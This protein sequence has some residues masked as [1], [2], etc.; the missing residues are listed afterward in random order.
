MSQ[1]FPTGRSTSDGWFELES[2]PFSVEAA[3]QPEAG[4]GFF[5]TEGLVADALEVV[6]QGEFRPVARAC[7]GLGSSV[8]AVDELCLHRR[9]VDARGYVPPLPPDEAGRRALATY[10]GNRLQFLFGPLR[11]R[12]EYMADA[13]A[14]IEDMKSETNRYRYWFDFV[15]AVQRLQDSHSTASGL[16]QFVQSNAGPGRI[17]LNV[18][19]VNG[20]ADLSHGQVPRDAQMPDVLVSHTGEGATWGLQAGDRLVAIDGQHPVSWARGLAGRSW[21]A[22]QV[23]DPASP[24][25]HLEGLRG[26]IPSLARAITVIRCPGGVC[27]A[28]ETL[29]VA[30][31]AIPDGPFMR[32]ACDH[33]P[34][35]HLADVPANHS[36]DGD[37]FT[38]IALESDETER[39]HGM[40]WDSLYGAGSSTGTAIAQAAASWRSQG[41]RGVILDHRTGN[42]GTKDAAMPILDFTT[43]T[44]YSEAD[45]WRTFLDDKGPAT[46]ADGMAL[47]ETLK[48]D[49]SSLALVGSDTPS[50]DVPVAL[51]LTRDVSASDYFPNA[52]KGSPNTRI[53][54]PNPTN[55][56]FSTFLQFSYWLGLSY[57]LA[58]QDTV[59][60]DGTMLC[61][62]GVT[63]DEIVEP[64]QSDLVQ[65]IDSVYVAALAWVRANLKAPEAP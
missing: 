50:L 10:L 23:N 58:A 33:R 30:Q 21:S 60:H 26:T 6:P 32:V 4:V 25:Q 49:P 16:F 27:G 11:N 64:R 35:I 46:L 55:G 20:D 18:C 51:L 17:P 48:D 56:A 29:T 2:A 8:C 3:R 40:V 19:F 59:N 13:M 53:F 57:Q 9:C 43:P 65:G 37:V 22:Q 42:G 63:P 41:A 54:G 52:L 61:G 38:G 34:G 24:A 12:A 7:E 36:V 39:I 45:V 62:H 15:T 14:S 44:R 31:Q 47:F 5:A 28:P 1:L